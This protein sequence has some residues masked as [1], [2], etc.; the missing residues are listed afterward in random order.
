MWMAS[1]NPKEGDD[2]SGAAQKTQ[3]W[4]RTKGCGGY[5]KKGAQGR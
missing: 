2:G 1:T 5:G 4:R 3:T